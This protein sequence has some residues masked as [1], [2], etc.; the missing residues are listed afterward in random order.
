MALLMQLECLAAQRPVLMIAEDVHWMDPTSLE[1][2]AL[3]VERAAALRLLLL[4]TARP[5]FAPPWPNHAHVSTLQLT[6]LGRKD[7]AALIGRVACGKPLPPEVVSEILARTDGVPLFIEELTK[8]V[9]ESGLL[10]KRRDDFVLDHPLPSL[11]IPAT[12]QASLMA[13]L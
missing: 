12:L 8:T 1:L 9:L 11:A 3:V 10:R 7:G 2:L 4:V 5:E 6:R 13:R